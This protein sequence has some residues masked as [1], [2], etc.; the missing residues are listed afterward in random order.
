MTTAEDEKKPGNSSCVTKIAAETDHLLSALAL[1]AAK[2]R[3]A[4]D[5]GGKCRLNRA[6]RRLNR[7]IARATSHG[8]ILSDPKVHARLQVHLDGIFSAE[9][10][11]DYSPD[12]NWSALGTH[13][14][15]TR[16]WPL[17]SR[18]GSR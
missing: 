5:Q 13:P 3:R 1:A 4:R 12:T 17:A 6:H 11:P 9:T 8:L 7:A 2:V 15:R 16:S 10:M 18:K 14:N